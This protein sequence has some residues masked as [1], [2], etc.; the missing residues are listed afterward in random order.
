MKAKRGKEGEG[1]QDKRN[2]D[3]LGRDGRQWAVA[4][5]DGTNDTTFC[6]TTPN[7]KKKKQQAHEN[8][9]EALNFKTI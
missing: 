9:A 7:E 6:V 3:R 2:K 4:N 8:K 5:R 1:G